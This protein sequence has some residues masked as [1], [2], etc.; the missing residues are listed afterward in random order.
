MKKK[1]L[2]AISLTCLMI[3]LFAISALAVEIDGIYYTLNG[4]GENA[5]AAVNNENATKCKLENVVIPSTVTYEGTT[6]TVN[7]V[8]DHAFSGSK[9]NWGNN[10]TVKTLYIPE[11]V[12]SIGNHFLRQCESIQS[13]TIKAKNEKGITLGDAEFYNCKN[14]VSVDMSESD[15][16]S[17]VQYTFHGCSSLVNVKLPPRLTK[18]GG[19]SFR[20]C[21]ALASLNLLDYPITEIGSWAFNGCAKL[22]SFKLPTSLVTLGNNCFQG[23][24]VVGT[25]IFPDTLTTIA[26]DSIAQISMYMVVFPDISDGHSFNYGAFHDVYPTVIIYEGDDYTDLTKSIESFK[27]YTNALPFSEYDPNTT[28]TGRT[29]FYGA[30]L[31]DKCNGIL[32][33]ERFNFT[34]YENEFYYASKCTNCQKDNVTESYEPMFINSGYSFAEYEK[35][36]ITL[37]FRVNDESIAAYEKITGEAVKYGLYAATEKTLGNNDILDESGEIRS[38]VISAEIPREQFSLL[39]IKIFGFNTEEQRNALFIIGAYVI[40]EKNGAKTV[41]YIQDGTPT[42]GSKHAYVTFNGVVA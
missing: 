31:C 4:S 30:E 24:P 40:S 3:C 15:I 35:G 20:D 29:I 37:G 42:E 13:V 32:E 28:Y 6:Y 39:D 7:K 9:S 1:I 19:Q 11:T 5:T 17:F 41:S 12:K 36:V 21:K 38:G 10:Q 14:L 27:G 34:G 33:D 2:L 16:I 18:I 26:N 23:T 22:S 25:L 8:D